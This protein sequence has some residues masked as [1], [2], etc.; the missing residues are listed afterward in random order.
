MLTLKLIMWHGVYHY[1]SQLTTLKYTKNIL[2]ILTIYWEE[3]WRPNNI[4]CTHC[5]DKRHV[6]QKKDSQQVWYRMCV[7]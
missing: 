7:S 1:L 3:C 5:M 4:L 6:L 2:F